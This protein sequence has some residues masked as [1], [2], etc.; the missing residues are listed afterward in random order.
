MNKEE[1]AKM[2]NRYTVKYRDTENG[3]EHTKYNLTELEAVRTKESCDIYDN[4]EFISVKPE[5]DWS[6][7]RTQ[8]PEKP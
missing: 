7:Y 6:K 2:H 5:P 4:L 8:A 3:Q 1:L